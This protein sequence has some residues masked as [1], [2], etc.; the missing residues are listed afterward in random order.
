MVFIDQLN[1]VWHIMGAKLFSVKQINSL[2]ICT[3]VEDPVA[4]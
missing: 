1:F 3:D 4:E 2:H